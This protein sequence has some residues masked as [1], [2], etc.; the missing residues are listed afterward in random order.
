MTHPLLSQPGW[1]AWRNSADVLL[2]KWRAIQFALARV[3][4]SIQYSTCLFSKKEAPPTPA[5]KRQ[6]M[7]VTFFTYMWQSISKKQLFLLQP[8]KA[9]KEYLYLI[10]FKD[11]LYCLQV[12][13]ACLS[14]LRIIYYCSTVKLLGSNNVLHLL[15]HLLS[16]QPIPGDFFTIFK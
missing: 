1:G 15:I 14:G 2:P 4:P 12:S 11:K 16:Q 13:P 6:K 3:W 7:M 10:K 5:K 8:I 9:E